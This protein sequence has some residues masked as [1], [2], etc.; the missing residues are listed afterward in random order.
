MQNHNFVCLTSQAPERR[1]KRQWLHERW[2]HADAVINMRAIVLN[3]DDV[4]KL[5]GGR[6]SE[7]GKACLKTL[8]YRKNEIISLV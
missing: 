7:T 4:E 6:Q 2:N 5:G 1:G 3:K 8:E